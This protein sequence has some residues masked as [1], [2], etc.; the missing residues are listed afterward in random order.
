MR[1][2]LTQLAPVLLGGTSAPTLVS[3]STYVTIIKT[4][5]GSVPLAPTPAMDILEEL[6]LQMV[7]QFFT[8]M[9]Y[10]T[11]LVLT[12]RSSFEFA[13][14]FREN[15]IEIIRQTGVSDQARAYQV[16]VEQLGMYF[17]NLKNLE[18]THPS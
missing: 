3:E 8:M 7:E 11:E 16:L 17:K 5:L 18:S 4:G 2:L 13:R 6:T 15:L 9:K 14:T 12:G 1:Q 10:C